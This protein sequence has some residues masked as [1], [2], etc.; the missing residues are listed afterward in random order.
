MSMRSDRCASARSL[1]LIL[2]LPVFVFCGLVHAQDLERVLPK[3]DQEDE[4]INQGDVEE[5]NA[6]SILDATSVDTLLGRL[7][8]SDPGVRHEALSALV[9]IRDDAKFG[10]GLHRKLM[11][12]LIDHVK[13]GMSRRDV[14][15]L[16]GEPSSIIDRSG[17]ERY[18]RHW[19]FRFAGE[20]VLPP[21]RIPK[22]ELEDASGFVY[23]WAQLMEFGWKV[24]FDG[25]RVHSFGRGAVRQER[26]R[27]TEEGFPTATH[28]QSVGV[29]PQK[30][31]RILDVS[32]DGSLALLE[33]LDSTM[34]VANIRTGAVSE[35]PGTLQQTIAGSISFDG[36]IAATV[37]ERKQ[38]H[39]WDIDPSQVKLR[40]SFRTEDEI[41][42]VALAPDATTMVV[43]DTTFLFS[44]LDTFTGRTLTKVSMIGSG[45]PRLS[46][47]GGLA[48][49]F[50]GEGQFKI[51]RLMD[52]H[53][54]VGFLEDRDV[55]NV[56]A[57]ESS[58]EPEYLVYATTERLKAW[59]TREIAVGWS[60]RG[61]PIW[62]VYL[63][64]HERIN[65]VAVTMKYVFLLHGDRL[66]VFD[67]RT[68]RETSLSSA[69]ESG[70]AI[71]D[72]R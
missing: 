14:L 23:R 47:G 24:Y 32:K 6:K 17:T 1:L 52:V 19:G 42:D 38:I 63:G 25:H 13:V 57:F 27:G 2:G 55:G 71:G 3:Q 20:E 43:V 26:R 35:F 31:S 53:H 36:R 48:L 41:I 28:D 59:R 46:P 65:G 22:H 51:R 34:V 45:Y 62:E 49:F 21:K 9:R 30:V 60:Q 16:L 40:T 66:R 56:V 18:S 61:N 64:S 72:V 33:I 70:G 68:G 15:A 44:L 50:Q 12:D 10:S 29:W 7:G 4:A 5:D 8:H 39:V 58:H 11:I 37:H 69:S 67:V 54:L